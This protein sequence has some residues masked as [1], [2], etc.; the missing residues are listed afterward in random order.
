MLQSAQAPICQRALSFPVAG[1]DQR[2][3]C[4]THVFPPSSPA[5]QGGALAGTSEELGR[6]LLLD[7]L[8]GNADRLPIPDL[9]WRGNKGNLLHAGAGEGA[10][11]GQGG[12]Q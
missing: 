4:P 12:L 7:M 3:C 8:L 9:G 6:L 11:R 10:G 2:S 1:A 5:P